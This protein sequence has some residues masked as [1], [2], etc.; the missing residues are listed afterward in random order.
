MTRDTL[1]ALCGFSSTQALQRAHCDWVQSAL[2]KNESMRQA[3]WS[4]SIAVGSERFT[5]EVKARLGLT[6]RYR[7]VVRADDSYALREPASAYAGYFDR[8]NAPL[9][10]ENTHVWDMNAGASDA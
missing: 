2:A 6:A 8:E 1:A 10:I 9:R 4:E 5:Q 3:Y 7:D